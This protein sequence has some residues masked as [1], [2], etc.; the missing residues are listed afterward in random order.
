MKN[1]W[2][3]VNFIPCTSSYP[4]GGGVFFLGISRPKQ[5]GDHHF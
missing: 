1:S 4:L 3:K 5:L 2:M